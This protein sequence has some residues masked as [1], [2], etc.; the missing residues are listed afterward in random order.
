VVYDN[1]DVELG[2]INNVYYNWSNYS[3]SPAK[4][5]NANPS[6]SYS[7]SSSTMNCG[8][9]GQHACS[10]PSLY[11]PASLTAAGVTPGNPLPVLLSGFTALSNSD[12]TNT[13]SWETQMEQNSSRMEI[14]RSPD[15]GSWSTVG[16]VA[17]QGNST[18]PTSYSYTDLSPL[19]GTNYYRLKM[20]DLDGSAVYS[21]VKVLKGTIVSHISFFPN[22][23]RDFVNVTLGVV[24]GT[25]TVRLINQA[26]VVLQEKKVE[27]ASGTTVTFPLQQVASGFYILSVVSTDGVHENG[28][29]LVNRQ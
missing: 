23:A 25:V 20:I 2:N 1:S 3:A 4:S 18:S 9:S 14:E 29:V 11:G 6:K 22:P 27:S 15:G 13:L 5:T 26:G 8:G 21:E 16:T 28:K 19:A 7:T 24:T 10:N 12:G 17:A